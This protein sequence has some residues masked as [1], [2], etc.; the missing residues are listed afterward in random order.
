[1]SATQK[2]LDT[3]RAK[4]SV[5]VDERDQ[6]ADAAITRKEAE[7]RFDHASPALTLSVYSHLFV[8]KDGEAADAID[9]VFG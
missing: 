3:L 9:R 1:M 5:L 6:V 2:Q 4:I 8:N 7:A